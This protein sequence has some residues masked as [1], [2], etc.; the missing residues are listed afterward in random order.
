MGTRACGV[1]ICSHVPDDAGHC[2][3][4]HGTGTSGTREGPA[5]RGC[6]TKAKALSQPGSTPSH[7]S[8]RASRPSSH[9]RDRSSSNTYTCG[10]HFQ[11]PCH[12][13]EIAALGTTT[14]RQRTTTRC[15]YSSKL[16]TAK[17]SII[18]SN[19]NKDQTE[20]QAGQRRR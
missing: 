5:A 1:T 17:T 16:R 9:P 14:Y 11:Y 20:H 15:G 4:L 19:A 3:A 18:N 10:D 7:T 12:P 8:T 13:Q 2:Y 6:V